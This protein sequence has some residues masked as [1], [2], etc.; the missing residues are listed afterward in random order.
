MLQRLSALRLQFMP[1]LVSAAFATVA[2][3]HEVA[4]THVRFA[5][6]GKGALKDYDGSRPLIIEFQAGERVPVNLQVSGEGF[7]LATPH[8]AL[9]LVATGHC[10][11]RVDSEGLR[12]S[13]DGQHF[14]K[15]SHPG[16]FRVG[17]WSRPGQPAKLEVS[18]AGPRH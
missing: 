7:E 9:E 3:G 8:P 11:V 5:D 17:F 18:I 12:I 15:P 1:F 13:R 14:D 4:A 16:A 6:L 10:F 2:C